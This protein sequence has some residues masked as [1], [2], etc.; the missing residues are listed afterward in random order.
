[1]LNYDK[2]IFNVKEIKLELSDNFVQFLIINNDY[3][4]K[5]KMPFLEHIENKK[6]GEKNNKCKTKQ[7]GNDIKQRQNKTVIR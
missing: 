3:N 7:K 6:I 1:M 5:Y 4:K 2:Y